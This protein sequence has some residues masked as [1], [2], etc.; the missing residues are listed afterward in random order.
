M[1]C[2]RKFHQTIYRPYST[3][4]EAYDN[5]NETTEINN[6]LKIYPN[7][8][9]D[10]INIEIDEEHSNDFIVSIYNSLGIK[11]RETWNENTISVEDLP[12]G[13]YFINVMSEDCNQT[14]KFLKK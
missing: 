5:V 14:R 4:K 13:I 1:E 12:S 2:N 7:P 10:F 11:V 6:T 9:N 3:F 8:T